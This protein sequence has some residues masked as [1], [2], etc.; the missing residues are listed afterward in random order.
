MKLPSFAILN[1]YRYRQKQ[2]GFFDILPIR[3]NPEGEFY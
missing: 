3:A 1:R 2:S